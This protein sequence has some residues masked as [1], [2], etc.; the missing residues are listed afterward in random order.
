MLNL[1]SELSNEL[2]A[3]H[4]QEESY[5]FA[6]ARANELRDG[7]KNTTY[8]H[9][10]ASQRRHYNSI[11][12]LFDE[13]DIWRDKEEDL[14]DLVSSYFGKLFSI[15][16]PTNFEQ[17]LEGLET[18]I[19]DEMN[20]LL[21]KEPTDEEIK[22]ALFQMHPNKAPG[23]DG[24]HALFFQKFW[25]IVGHDICSFVKNWWRG[26]VVLKDVNKTCVVLIP[27]C[28]NPKRMT[29]FRP[30]SCCNVLYKYLKDYG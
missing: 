9:K 30:I 15:E 19:T 21:N 12:G 14:E 10:K 8:F 28:A 4:K 16:V 7:D 23:P 26:L 18:R 5:W 3:L 22:D 24:M 17:A 2:D 6:R 20:T 25:Y 1:C 29:E 27:K 11:A 13:N